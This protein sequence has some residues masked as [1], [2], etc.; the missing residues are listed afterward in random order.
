MNHIELKLAVMK[1]IYLFLLLPVVFL[2]CTVYY[3]NEPQPVDSKNIYKM[4][5]KF[6]G[7]WYI[8]D[9]MDLMR[10][11]FDSISIGKNSYHLITRDQ[12]RE[13]RNDIDS[14]S[15]I[16]I[17]NDKIYYTED[18]MLNGG[19]AFYWSNDTVIINTVENE[20]VELGKKAHLRKIDYGYILNTNHDKMIDWWSI[21]FIDTR[22]KENMVIRCIKDEDVE[23]FPSYNI[24]SKDFN[25]YIEAKWSAG[26]VNEFIDKGGFS[27]TVLILKYSEELTK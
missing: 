6:I 11:D 4:P 10:E 19:Y 23:K 8:K 13:T 1:H 27:D 15:S 22:D 25:N 18:G 17:M 26:E 16:F 9:S 7:S 2:S 24:L 14:D 21:K 5:I 12:V 3:F 20:L